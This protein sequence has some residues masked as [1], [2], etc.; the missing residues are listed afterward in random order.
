MKNFPLFRLPLFV[1]LLLITAVNCPAI[2]PRNVLLL[3]NERSMDS[4]E[5]ANHFIQL[6]HIPERN[7]VYLELPDGVYG[8]SAEISRDEF[9]RYVW[10]P[11]WK[12]IKARNL[13]SEIL[14][15]VYSVDFPV[16]FTG[17]PQISL[18]A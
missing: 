2:S 7:V 6:R 10:D 14:A 13:G 17:E 15:W 12:V 3:V 8:C 4:K 5:V 18:Q 1:F 11:A 9:M 16:K